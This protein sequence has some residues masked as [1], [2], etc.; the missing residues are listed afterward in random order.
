MVD[1]VDFSEVLRQVA[2]G[3]L[4]Q[5]SV[6][7]KKMASAML[8]LVAPEYGYGKGPAYE[9]GMDRDAVERLGC[10]VRFAAAE[11]IGGSRFRTVGTSRSVG[12]SALGATPWEA[13]EKIHA[14]IAQGFERP[15]PLQYR[16]QV[17][18]K[19]YIDSLAA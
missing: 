8:Y 4:R 9:F 5:D 2:T 13:R 11:Q 7:Y 3:E 18:E 16:S 12:L 1:D 19:A 14:A 10:N 17:A 6:R 15:L